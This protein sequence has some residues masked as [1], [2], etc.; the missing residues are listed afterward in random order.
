MSSSTLPTTWTPTSWQQLDAGQQPDWPDGDA[1]SM[2]LR[3]CL[4]SFLSN[5]LDLSPI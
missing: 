1:L 4:V 3:E 5:H 2:A